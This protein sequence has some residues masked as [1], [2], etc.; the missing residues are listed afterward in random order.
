M[1]DWDIILIIVV[2][3]MGIYF[4]LWLVNR[5]LDNYSEALECKLRLKQGYITYEEVR[6]W[7]LINLTQVDQLIKE[8]KKEIKR[9]K[10]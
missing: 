3:L 8:Y 1:N 7:G 5:F 6:G 4:I 2:V 10:Q 9:R